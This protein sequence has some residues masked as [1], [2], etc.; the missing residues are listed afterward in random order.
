MALMDRLINSHQLNHNLYR[1]KLPSMQHLL[2][3]VSKIH[4]LT[5]PQ[6][7]PLYF[8]SNRI[9]CH[10]HPLGSCLLRPLERCLLEQSGSLDYLSYLL[11]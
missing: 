2:L 3:L 11:A 7:H 5:F 8:L 9:W 4:T 1:I 6:Q 10:L